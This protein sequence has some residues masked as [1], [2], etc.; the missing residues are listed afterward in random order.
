MYIVLRVP[1]TCNFVAIDSIIVEA[2]K[3]Q[4]KDAN[5]FAVLTVLWFINL[6]AQVVKGSKNSSRYLFNAI[7]WNY[8]IS[9]LILGK[10]LKSIWARSEPKICNTCVYQM[11]CKFILSSPGLKVQAKFIRFLSSLSSKTFTDSSSS[12]EPLY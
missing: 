7:R 8:R 3:Y 10:T 9:A 12:Q 6:L 1:Y 2:I 5:R 4:N 11:I